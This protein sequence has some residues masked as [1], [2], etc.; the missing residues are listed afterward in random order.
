MY[1][2]YDIE[3]NKLLGKFYLD[4]FPRKNKYSH[5]AQF[6][7]IGSKKMEHYYQLPIAALVI[8][9]SGIGACGAWFFAGWSDKLRGDEMLEL[10]VTKNRIKELEMDLNRLRTKQNNILPFISFS[11]DKESY[12]D[13]EVA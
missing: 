3:T 13:Q 8:I 9:S 2:T 6:S 4:L 10:E 5:A 7:I 11:G 12:L 1:E